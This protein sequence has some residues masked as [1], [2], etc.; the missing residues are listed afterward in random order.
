MNILRWKH[1]VSLPL[2]LALS[3]V[4]AEESITLDTIS[5][6]GNYDNVYVA[7]YKVITIENLLFNRSVYCSELL[8]FVPNLIVS[9]YGNGKVPTSII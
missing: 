4:E 8:E 2:L 1:C 5:V 6:I 7:S 3:L 9:A